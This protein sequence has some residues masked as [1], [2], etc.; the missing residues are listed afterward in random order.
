MLKQRM[1]EC[2]V[3]ASQLAQWVGVSRCRIYAMCGGSYLP[4]LTL[5]SAVANVLQCAP[6]DLFTQYQK[7]GK[8]ITPIDLLAFLPPEYRVGTFA[9]AFNDDVSCLIG[10]LEEFFNKPL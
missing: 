2:G 1:K 3:S 10:S 5:A 6:G 8:V 9:A 4:S 7:D